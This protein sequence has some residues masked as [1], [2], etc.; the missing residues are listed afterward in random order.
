[1][2]G[3]M[4]L[5]R[6]GL[7]LPGLGL[8]EPGGADLSH[9]PRVVSEGRQLCNF[10]IFSMILLKINNILK[11]LPGCMLSQNEE[12]YKGWPNTSWPQVAEQGLKGKS[13]R[14]TAELEA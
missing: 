3:I 8:G 7:K 9:I 10:Q 6:K 12:R 14:I 13:V 5:K 11:R 1:M 2:F 4:E